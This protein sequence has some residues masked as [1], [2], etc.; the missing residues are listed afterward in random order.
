MAAGIGELLGDVAITSLPIGA[1]SKTKYM[2]ALGRG[3]KNVL[4]GGISAATHAGQDVQRCRNINL[5]ES[6][7]EIALSGLFPLALVQ[8]RFLVPE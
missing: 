7:T 6:A 8:S 5:G 1:A 4:A 3:G 2:Q